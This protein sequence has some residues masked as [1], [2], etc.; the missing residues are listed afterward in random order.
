M[1]TTVIPWPV[2]LKQTLQRA[3]FK[4]EEDPDATIATDM[5]TGPRKQ[6]AR[7]FNSIPRYA[8][9]IWFSKDEYAEFLTYFRTDLVNGSL[10][11]RFVNPLTGLEEDYSFTSKPIASYVGWATVAVQFSVEQLP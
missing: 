3:T 2:G 6:R 11:T 1:A 9:S 4:V 10:G 5:A 7:Y 8:M